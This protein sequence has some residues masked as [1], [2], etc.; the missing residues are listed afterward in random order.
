M[1]IMRAVPDCA[2]RAAIQDMETEKSEVHFLV[3]IHHGSAND[4]PLP[5]NR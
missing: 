5:G 1:D 2:A 3:V 4:Y